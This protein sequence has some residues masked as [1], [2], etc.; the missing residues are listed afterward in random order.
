MTIPAGTSI[1]VADDEQGIRDLFQFTL[2]PLGVEL[3]MAVDGWEAFQIIQT[4][5]FDLVILDV[6][7]PRLSGPELLEKIRELRPEQKVLVVSSSSDA[8]HSFEERVTASGAAIC[9]FKPVELDV[10]LGTIERTL[11]GESP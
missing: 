6:H 10:L 8:S 4:R 11:S 7:M 1:L 3:V 5:S 2:E 9:L